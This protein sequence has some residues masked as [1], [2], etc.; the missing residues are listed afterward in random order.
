MYNKG[1]GSLRGI[2]ALFLVIG[3]ILIMITITE[4][5]WIYSLLRIA[6]IY[7]PGPVVLSFLTV[8]RELKIPL[9]VLG[10]GGILVGIAQFR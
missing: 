2:G 8:I 1:Q 9:M 5:T 10:I 3:F 6:G 4:G 7:Y